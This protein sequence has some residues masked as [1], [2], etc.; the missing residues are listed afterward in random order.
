MGWFQVP[1]W[2]QIIP[3]P[4]FPALHSS[5]AVDLS[6]SP[7]YGLVCSCQYTYIEIFHNFVYVSA[8]DSGV[9]SDLVG[10]LAV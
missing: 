5:M 6:S 7:G 1:F 9:F 3:H 8:L 4:V 2:L 10:Q